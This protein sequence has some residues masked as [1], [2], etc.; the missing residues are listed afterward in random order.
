MKFLGIDLH[1]NCFT[2][3]LITEEGKKVNISYQLEPKSLKEFYSL[4]TSDMYVMV[5]AS[6]NTFKFVELIR[7]R[8]NTVFWPIRTSSDL[9]LW[10]RK[11]LIR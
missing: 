8:V 9:F 6:T 4:L 3:C 5:E 1:S 2:C 11:K 7:D 10:S